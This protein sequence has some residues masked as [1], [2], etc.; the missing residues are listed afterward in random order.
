MVLFSA[1]LFLKFIIDEVSNSYA[2]VNERIDE[3]IYK[4]RAGLI[5][6]IENIATE[7]T[8]KSEKRSWPRYVICRELE[9]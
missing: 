8:I 3:L 5:D 1:F 9:D 7:T 6:E 2:N 4:E